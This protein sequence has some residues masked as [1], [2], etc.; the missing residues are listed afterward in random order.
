M[1]RPACSNEWSAEAR[2]LTTRISGPVSLADV[3]AWIEGL[4]AAEDCIPPGEPFRMLI[5]LR[6]YEVADVD[7]EVHKVQ[8]EIIPRFLAR[9]GFR[10]AYLSLFEESEELAIETDGPICAAAAHVHHDCN[11]MTLYDG[12]LGRA[13]E[14]FFC[15]LSEA[16]EWLAAVEVE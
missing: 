5:D 3:E 1:T 2:L 13:N 7:P 12:R 14:R 9:H 4:R 6:G 10:A 16:E 15:D 11:K 8:R